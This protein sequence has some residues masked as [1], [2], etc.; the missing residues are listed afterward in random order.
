MD[1]ILHYLPHRPPFLFVDEIVEYDGDTLKARKTVRADEPWIAGH[2]PGRPIMPGV[3]ICEAVFQAGALLVAKRMGRRDTADNRV[4]VL[5]RIGEVKFRQTVRPGDVLDLEVT[6][7][8]QAGPAWRIKG[9][10][11]VG[12]KTVVTLEFTAMLVEDSA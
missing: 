6:L 5:T 1:E 10:A 7:D 8:Q 11:S 9:K 3:L 12:G 4:P 2:Y